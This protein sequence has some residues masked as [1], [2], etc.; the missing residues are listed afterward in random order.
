[1]Y[2]RSDEFANQAL[3]RSDE[4]H[5]KASSEESYWLRLHSPCKQLSSLPPA[6]YIVF[7]FAGST[8]KANILRLHYSGEILKGNNH[9]SF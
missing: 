4:M 1:L 9:R 6:L 8:K 2:H 5:V 7:I 3:T